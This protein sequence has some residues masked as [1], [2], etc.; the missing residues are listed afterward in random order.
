MGVLGLLLASGCGILPAAGPSGGTLVDSPEAS[1]IHV[2]PADARDRSENEQ[3]VRDE[4]V[5][6][7]VAK[8][9]VSPKPVQ[10]LFQAGDTFHLTMFSIAPWSG[11]GAAAGQNGA[12]LPGPL[13][14]GAYVVAE[15]GTVVLPYVGTLAIRGK[16]LAEAEAA[17]ADRYSKL[18]IMQSPAAKL[19]VA[20]APQSNIIVTGAL[21]APA[22][23]PWTPAGVTLSEALTKALGNGAE[24]LGSDNQV[25]GD[26]WAVVVSVLRGDD[27]PVQLPVQ[28]ALEQR[29]PL[30]PAD[31]VVVT[32]ASA[33]RI[34]VLGGGVSKDGVYEY[35]RTPTLASVL[36]RASGLDTN[37]AN[38][39]AVFV[40]EQ[41]GHGEKPVLFDF[42]WNHAAGLIASQDFPLRDGDLVYVDEAPIVPVQKAL[43]VLFEAAIPINLA[44]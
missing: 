11:G 16:D 35:A 30:Q 18:G 27:A 29:L 32:K 42:A 13:D 15:D 31:R 3:R 41:R 26:R 20:S 9:A 19:E 5:Q 44:K 39:R 25:A 34:V 4:A 2:T 17:I 8:L 33:F 24:V 28:A 1:V 23:I 43:N 37:V 6:A 10:F 36:A 22:A 7:A 40:L 21:G 38:D 12:G 14:F